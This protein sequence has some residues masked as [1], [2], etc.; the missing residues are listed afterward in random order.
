MKSVRI[1]QKKIIYVYKG[2]GSELGLPF[3][4]FDGA[5]I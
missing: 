5:A 1:S 4:V 2:M 3:A